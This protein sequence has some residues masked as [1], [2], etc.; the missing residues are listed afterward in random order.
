MEERSILIRCNKIS[1]VVKLV[2]SF[3]ENNKLYMLIEKPTGDDLKTSVLKLGLKFLK[4]PEVK[5]CIY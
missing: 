4:E 1:Q 2:D 5:K 3:S